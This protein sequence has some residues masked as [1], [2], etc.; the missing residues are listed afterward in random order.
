MINVLTNTVRLGAQV[1]TIGAMTLVILGLF[2]DI[3]HDEK[4]KYNSY[5]N[6]RKVSPG[7]RYV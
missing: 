3:Y 5:P 4:E 7:W 6:K 2:H 1:A